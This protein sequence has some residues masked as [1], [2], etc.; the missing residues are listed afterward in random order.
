MAS[1]K[2]DKDHIGVFDNYFDKDFC[3]HYI[4]FYK[5][6]EKNKLVMERKTPSHIKDDNNYD[7]ISNIKYANKQGIKEFNVNYTAQDF[8]EKFFT[9][10]YPI[11][12]K[13]YSILDLFSKHSIQDVKLQKTVP[14]T[15]YHIWHCESGDAQNRNRIMAF[16]LYLNTVKEGGETE[17]LYQ[18]KRIKPQQGRLVMFPTSY[19]HV[20]RGNPPLKG[21]KYILT[22]WVELIPG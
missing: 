9:E 12:L 20:H 21:D 4:S 15:G 1:N 17:F 16:I 11:Y 13:K 3:E 7:I 5:E 22:G 19:T 10:I 18:T 8:T 14:Q 6:M 2:I